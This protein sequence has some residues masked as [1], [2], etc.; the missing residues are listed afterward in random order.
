MARVISSG[1]TDFQ[2]AKGANSARKN[3]QIDC[4]LSRLRRMALQ[5]EKESGAAV[6]DLIKGIKHK[7][8]VKNRIS[9]P[10]AGLPPMNDFVYR[11][12]K[13]VHNYKKHEKNK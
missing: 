5:D 13:I 10:D 8:Q 4:A 7:R 2:F 6:K 9:V 11:N 12:S 1:I 3:I